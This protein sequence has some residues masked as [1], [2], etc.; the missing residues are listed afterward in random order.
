MSHCIKR[1]PW[2]CEGSYNLVHLVVEHRDDCGQP[3]YLNKRTGISA[4]T[5][6]EILSDDDFQD[7]ALLH[8]SDHGSTHCKDM[9]TN[10]SRRTVNK[11]TAFLLASIPG[12]LGCKQD[13]RKNSYLNGVEVASKTVYR[14]RGRPFATIA[15]C[16][17]ICLLVGVWWFCSRVHIEASTN[18]FC[19]F[20]REFRLAH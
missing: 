5:L 12:Q 9:G 13:K 17:M 20:G 7:G 4:R 3:C 18:V 11:S 1:T 2:N 10:S 19:I 8:V 15:A 16:Q 14:S 6:R